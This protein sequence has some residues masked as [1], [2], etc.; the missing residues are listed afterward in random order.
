MI[1]S[2]IFEEFNNKYKDKT[3][4]YTKTNWETWDYYEQCVRHTAF[5]YDMEFWVIYNPSSNMV[6]YEISNF[7]VETRYDYKAIKITKFIP[8][9][10]KY[11]V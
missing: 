7:G 8:D 1:S 11:Y 4:K 9:E 10:I 3:Y 6:L 2:K 5:Y